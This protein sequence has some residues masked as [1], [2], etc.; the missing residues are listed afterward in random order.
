[1]ET[2]DIIV[3]IPLVYFGFKGFQSGILKEILSIVGIVLAVFLTLN[4]LNEFTAYTKNLFG[5]SQ[6]YNPFIMGTILFV[7]VMICTSV[8]IYFLSKLVNAIQLSV[9]NKLLGLVFG[10]LKAGIIV[11][12][13]LIFL[14]GFN[15]PDKT[16]IEQS[17][18]YPVVIKIA[19]MSYDL[20]AKIYPGASNFSDVIKKTIDENNPLNNF[21]F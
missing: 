16:A 7:S 12:S 2:L 9:V 13:A 11:S 14:S 17:K 4:Y 21:S 19:P 3:L 15:F 18:T 1:M 20:I 8:L 6:D 5:F 10:A